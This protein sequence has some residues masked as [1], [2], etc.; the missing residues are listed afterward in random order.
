MSCRRLN[1]NAL[2]LSYLP[3]LSV[4]ETVEPSSY[5]L[6]SSHGILPAM[7]VRVTIC[8]YLSLPILPSFKVLSLP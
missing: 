7:E 4:G 2:L 6:L 8:K 1:E 5:S 3:V